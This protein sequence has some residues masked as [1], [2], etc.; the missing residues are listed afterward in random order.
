MGVVKIKISSKAKLNVFLGASS[1][2]PHGF[3]LLAEEQSKTSKD[4][5]NLSHT[6][7]SK[8]IIQDYCH[9]SLFLFS[10]GAVGID[11]IP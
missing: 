5:Q 9:R 8:V 1:R 7:S 2:G 4:S 10:K 3:S 11:T 6:I